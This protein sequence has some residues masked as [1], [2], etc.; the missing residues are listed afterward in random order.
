M[1][2][3]FLESLVMISDE[4]QPIVHELVVGFAETTRSLIIQIET[5]DHERGKMWIN[6]RATVAKEEAYRLSKRLGIPM[7]SLPSFIAESMDDYGKIVNANLY[8]LQDCLK[9]I[10]DSLD[11]EHCHYAVR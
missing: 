4:D 7:T 10:L 3:L 2:G 11:A 8:D 5:T 1:N 9:E 6:V